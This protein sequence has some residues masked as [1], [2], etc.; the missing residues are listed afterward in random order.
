MKVKNLLLAGLA[1]AAMTACSN[2]VDEIVNNG[3]QTGEKSAIMEFGIAFPALTRA[4][5]TGLPAEQDFKSATVIIAYTDG[6]KDVRVIDRN[7]FV[8]STENVLY[9]KEQITVEPK[10]AEVHVV[11]NSTSQIG[12][13]LNGNSWFTSVYNTSNYA[14]GSLVGISDITG[15]NNFLMSG[16]ATEKVT[17]VANE[18][19]DVRVKVS[20]IAAKLEEKTPTNN[21]FEVAKS[22]DNATMKDVAGEDVTV[23]ISVS[24]YSY[25][26]L[27]KT[28]NVF[29][30][31][32]AIEADLFQ[33]Y[34]VSEF[35]FTP[36]TGL[37][38]EQNAQHGDITYCLENYGAD[39]TMA[40]YKAVATINETAQT[41]WVDKDN[42]LY[43]SISEL[44]AKYPNIEEGTSIEN[45]WKNFG[46]RK[47]VD[48]VCYYK[49]NIMTDQEAK[50][51]RNNVYKMTVTGIANLGLPEPKDEPKLATLK[52]E[53]EV[54]PWTIQTNDFI[55]K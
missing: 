47:Y 33:P 19:K 6:T 12:T 9:T 52:L 36:I 51:V 15:E 31:T 45:C 2:D 21:A 37:K 55:L 25:A 38:G 42:I 16:S 18:S 30:K 8:E 11:L 13:T 3:N 46:V 54:E 40:I 1:V 41:F 53:V 10:E 7:L 17:F 5:E 50:I 32:A 4:T 48:G 29:P 22:Y 23:N 20:R 34:A 28:S 43:K 39:K 44:S 49:A 26:N 35:F 24:N 27:Q 14:K